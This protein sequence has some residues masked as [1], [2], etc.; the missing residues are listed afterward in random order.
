M[1]TDL[2]PKSGF[3]WKDWGII[4]ISLLTLLSTSYQFYFREVIREAQREERK[5]TALAID[6]RLERV[7]ERNGLVFV[8]VRLQA[9]NP[10]DRRIYVPAIWYSMFGFAVPDEPCAS[11][12]KWI[13]VGGQTDRLVLSSYN[14][15]KYVEIAA[16]RR[17]FAE[18]VWWEPKDVTTFDDIFAIPAD[19]F[20]YLKLYAT[21]ISARSLKGLHDDPMVLWG[22]GTDGEWA[23]LLI[24]SRF[25]QAL[26]AAAPTDGAASAALKG[27][28]VRIAE[29]NPSLRKL[30]EEEVKR[31]SESAESGQNYFEAALGISS[32]PSD[33]PKAAGGRPGGKLSERKA[34]PSCLR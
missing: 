16:Q 28:V 17:L 12:V 34:V 6:A 1:A 13:E 4:L 33:K 20:D 14:P 25:Y 21:Y 32:A 22:I 15:S 19:R 18:R 26:Q 9:S 8:R 24:T 5:P 2:P 11:Q 29:L 10:S 23:P 27:N 31:W 30:Y 7:A 3:S